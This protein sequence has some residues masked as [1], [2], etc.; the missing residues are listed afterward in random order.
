[1]KDKNNQFFSTVINKSV[2][3]LA[4]CLKIKLKNGKYICYTTN[5]SSV[6][7]KEEP[8]LIY[9]AK[10]FV[11]SAI[12]QNNLLTISNLQINLLIDDDM[13]KF[14]DM[15][16]NLFDGAEVWIFEFDFLNKPFSL[17]KVHKLIYGNI[18]NVTR[19]GLNFECNFNNL[20]ANYDFEIT[21]TVKAN[22]SNEFG[23][24]RCK[25]D[26]NQS[27]VTFEDSINYIVNNQNFYMLNTQQT[28]DYFKDG[29]LEITSGEAKGERIYIKNS[30]F[31]NNNII[32][33]LPFKNKIAIGDTVKITKGCNKTHTACVNYNNSKNYNGFPF[34]P[35]FQKFLK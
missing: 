21:N 32:T 23:D 6:S 10:G 14:D 25:Y 15:D 8:Y 33:Q 20:I 30:L 18:S 11:N 1:M 29:I 22:C 34:L 27:N 2:L 17:E 7:F 5:N 35:G 28:D 12:Q 3:T 31:L 9:K 24:N 4:K 26:L 13:I 19:K 16:K